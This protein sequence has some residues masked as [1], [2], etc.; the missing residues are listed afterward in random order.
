MCN[1]WLGA[2]MPFLEPRVDKPNYAAIFGFRP[3]SVN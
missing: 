3:Q 2:D 1:E